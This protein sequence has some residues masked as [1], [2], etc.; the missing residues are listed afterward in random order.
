LGLGADKTTNTRSKGSNTFEMIGGGRLFLA[1][2]VIPMKIMT[3][4]S[5]VQQMAAL[6]PMVILSI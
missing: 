3:A 4:K 1:L 5:T 2:L 6:A